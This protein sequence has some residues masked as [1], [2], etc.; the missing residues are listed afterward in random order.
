MHLAKLSNCPAPFRVIDTLYSI[1]RILFAEVGIFILDL[2]QFII[3]SSM[4]Q[5]Q[6]LSILLRIIYIRQYNVQKELQT[7]NIP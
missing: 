3:F 6:K 4:E 7:C 1:S 2:V 5:L